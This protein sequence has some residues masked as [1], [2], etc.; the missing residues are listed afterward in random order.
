MSI[1]RK[2]TS[3][4]ILIVYLSINTVFLIKYGLRQSVINVYA[5]TFIYLV[6]T[7]LSMFF[8]KYFESFFNKLKK[9]NLY[10]LSICGFIFIG[11]VLVTYV[12]DGNTLNIDRWSALEVT[13]KSVLN[14]EY[15][16]SVKDHL[17]KTTSNLPA[18][19]FIALPF[20]LIGNIGLLQP[21]VFIFLITLLYRLNF[22]NARKLFFLTLLMISP[23]YLW[24]IVVK[25]DLMS[26][27]FLFVIFFFLWDTKYKNDYFK[28]PY[29]LAFLSAFFVFT[30]VIIVIPLTILL[31]K[32]FINT[33][34]KNKFKFCLGFLISLFLISLPI[35]FTLPG[36]NKIIEHNPF[37]HQTRVGPKYLQYVF[38]LLP[39]YISF[40]TKTFKE[41]L[42]NSTIV[43]TALLFLILLFYVLKFGLYKAIILSYFDIS[44]LGMILPFLIFYFTI[45]TFKRIN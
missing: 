1:F 37:N 44:Y 3:L 17:G 30:R 14:L 20:Y 40:Y 33:S 42:S 10:F 28:A 45:V 15:P 21:F 18:L 4:L 25:S 16:Y 27:I 19:F 13:I 24:E 2:H 43:L 23:A 12:I 31:F 7:C 41:F 5:L 8:I 22:S 26:N 36:C 9:F 6:F 29:L 39:F 35:L 32:K 38:L 34:I 11:F